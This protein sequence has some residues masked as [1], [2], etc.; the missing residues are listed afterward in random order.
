MQ[1]FS[2]AFE[3]T[4]VGVLLQN[5]DEKQEQPIVVM[6]RALQNLELNY[7]IMEKQAYALV[8]SFKQF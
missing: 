6:S 2:F 3:D 4:M 7:S 8:K 5:N 1:V